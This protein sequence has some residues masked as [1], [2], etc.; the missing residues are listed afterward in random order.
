MRAPVVQARPASAAGPCIEPLELAKYKY[1]CNQHDKHDRL[2]DKHTNKQ[3]NTN[4]HKHHNTLTMGF[5]SDKPYTAVTS[6]IDRLTGPTYEIDD[7]DEMVE[8]LEII[9]IQWTGPTEAARALRKK[10]KYGNTHAQLRAL[11]ILETLVSNGGQ[12]LAPLYNDDR[13]LERLRL[14]ACGQAMPGSAG[15]GTVD[16][17]VR[18]RMQNMFI[19]W[20]EELRDVKECQRLA[21]LYKSLP[22]QRTRARSDARDDE[23]RRHDYSRDDYTRDGDED[24]DDDHNNDNYRP[25]RDDPSYRTDRRERSAHAGEYAGE[26]VRANLRADAPRSRSAVS[27][28]ATWNSGSAGS[29][30][31]NH[32]RRSGTLQSDINIV[33]EAPKIKELL[34]D[35]GSAA[36]N[37]QNVL[38]HINVE[39]ELACDNKRA[40]DLFHRAKALRHKVLKYIHNIQSEEFVGPL[41]HANEELVEAL[42]QYEKKSMHPEEA[43]SNDEPA[44]SDSAS[45]SSV[46]DDDSDA[47]ASRRRYDADLSRTMRNMALSSPS[48]SVSASPATSKMRT[49]PPRPTSRPPSMSPGMKSRSPSPPAHQSYPPTKPYSHAVQEDDETDPFGD[50]HESANAP[51]HTPMW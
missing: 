34:A 46:S 6:T 3:T 4:K 27:G 1:K 38:Q 16:S 44:D 23:R 47:R 48:R 14:V 2:T 43:R 5:L 17:R 10:L 45:V 11:T 18:K 42:K 41:I 30:S 19:G 25:N 28:K 31:R 9:K 12:A 29:S 24:D 37:L 21:Q 22:R 40:V 32:Q 39:R 35:C 51:L 33:K 15:S 36:T 49:P 26:R 20:R 13:L 8:L 50:R 7:I